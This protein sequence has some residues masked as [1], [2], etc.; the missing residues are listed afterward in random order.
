MFMCRSTCFGRL[1][2]HHQELSTALTAFGFTLD[3]GCSS[4]V[5]RG[6]ARP[7]PTTYMFSL[8]S[9]IFFSH[10]WIFEATVIAPWAQ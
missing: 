7:R 4:V 3:R 9:S 1:H 6:M 5:G 8:A 2:T 10:L